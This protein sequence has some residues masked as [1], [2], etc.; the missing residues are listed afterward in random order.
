[1]AQGTTSE[2]LSALT[3]TFE[4]FV[5]W[6]LAEEVRAEWVE[7][8]VEF[9]GSV[10]LDHQEIG[11]FLFRL[12]SEY[13][14]AKLLGF[15]FTLEFLMRLQTRPSGR[16]PDILYVAKEHKARIRKNYLDG[17]GDLVVE[18]VSPDSQ[19]RDRRTILLE[20]Q[21]AGVREYW[22]IDPAKQQALFYELQK[23]GL[24]QAG[25]ISEDGIYHSAVLEG[26]W[27]DVNWLWQRPLPTMAMVR[28]ALELP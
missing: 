14:E 12:L 20:Y 7:G 9:M 16:L 21:Q 26:L 15:V 13:V 28:K 10:S 23:N 3:L 8:K 11:N 27:L 25:V 2:P 22:L 18:I 17:A 6:A 24:Y 19:V 1:M 4:E 5:A